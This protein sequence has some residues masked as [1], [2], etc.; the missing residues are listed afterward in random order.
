MKNPVTSHLDLA[1]HVRPE[2]SPLFLEKRHCSYSGNQEPLEDLHEQR[3]QTQLIALIDKKFQ[4]DVGS[5]PGSV[6]IVR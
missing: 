1:D 3:G 6:S 4:V 2:M 5:W